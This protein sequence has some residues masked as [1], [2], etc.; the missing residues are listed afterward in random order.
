M[1]KIKC[2]GFD[3]DYTLAGEYLNFFCHW[4]SLEYC[5]LLSKNQLLLGLLQLAGASSVSKYIQFSVHCTSIL[6][7]SLKFVIC[8]LYLVTSHV[9]VVQFQ[10]IMGVKETKA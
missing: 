2:F 7:V 9:A 6:G 5:L 1:E 3:M 4:L 8:K 10:V